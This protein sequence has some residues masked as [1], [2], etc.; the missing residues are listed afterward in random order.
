MPKPTKPG[1]GGFVTMLPTYFGKQYQK[2]PKQLDALDAVDADGALQGLDTH[3]RRRLRR[4]RRVQLGLIIPPGMA[5]FAAP[6]S[7]Y[8]AWEIFQGFI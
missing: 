6:L 2:T 3:H 7:Q 8:S 1:F 5:P 4:V